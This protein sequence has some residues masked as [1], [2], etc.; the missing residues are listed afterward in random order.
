[1]SFPKLACESLRSRLR[2]LS[3]ESRKRDLSDKNSEKSAVCEK[4]ASW[5]AVCF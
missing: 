1:M 2:D 5:L 3:D 4:P